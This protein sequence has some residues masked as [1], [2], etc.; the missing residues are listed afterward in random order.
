MEGLEDEVKSI[1]QE[2]KHKEINVK[3]EVLVVPCLN[4]KSSKKTAEK[5]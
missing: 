3:K 2:V 4:N 5:I 1:P